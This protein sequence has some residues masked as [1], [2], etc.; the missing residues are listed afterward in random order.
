VGGD[1][2]HRDVGRA[3][4]DVLQDLE[5]ADL[6]HHQVGDDDVEAPA[7]EELDRLRAVGGLDDLVALALEG[8]GEDLAEVRFVVDDEE[9]RGG[10]ASL[11]TTISRRPGLRATPAR[12]CRSRPGA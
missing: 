5:P 11:V 4:E 9:L 8:R 10:H 12:W 1:Q 2:D 7:V 6:G 3:V